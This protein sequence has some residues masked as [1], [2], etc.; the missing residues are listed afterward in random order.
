MSFIN[1]SIQAQVLNPSYKRKNQ[2]A[3]D[4]L[5]DAENGINVFS[6]NILE[7]RNYKY[8]GED[9]LVTALLRNNWLV[10]SPTKTHIINANVT[11]EKIKIIV[12]ALSRHSFLCFV[13]Y[14]LNDSPKACV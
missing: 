7:P 4:L 12:N 6:W 5:K 14:K 8:V 9:K 2:T 3:A 1:N 13:I 10:R 11:L